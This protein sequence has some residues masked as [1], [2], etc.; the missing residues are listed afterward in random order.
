MNILLDTYRAKNFFCW[1]HSNYQLLYIFV[2]CSFFSVINV[3]FNSYLK[4]VQTKITA[5]KKLKTYVFWHRQEIPAVVWVTATY[6]YHTLQKKSITYRIKQK[7][8]KGH[9]G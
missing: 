1:N 3:Y 7:Y 9:L 2:V 8:G 5:R 4:K 6:S